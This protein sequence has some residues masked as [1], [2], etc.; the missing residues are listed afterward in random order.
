MSTVIAIIIV[1]V[2][3]GLLFV[4]AIAE[5][6]LIGMTRSR[7]E[8]LAEE[9]VPGADK[10]VAALADRGKLLAPFLALALAAQLSVC[11]LYTSDAA[12]E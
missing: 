7:A 8:A 9:Q 11:L 12:D 5:S 6:S 3:W 1:L 10:L 4:L 2:L